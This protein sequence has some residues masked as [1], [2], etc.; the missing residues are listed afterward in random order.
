MDLL[1][2]G[3]TGLVLTVIV[4]ATSMLEEK[5]EDAVEGEDQ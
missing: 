1:T 5:I 3:T 4:G 2:I